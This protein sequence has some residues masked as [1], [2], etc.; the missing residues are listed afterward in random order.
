MVIE[1]RDAVVAGTKLTATYKKQ[2]YVC[3]VE[4]GADGKLA[5]LFNGKSYNSPSSAGTAVIGTACNGWRFWSVEGASPVPAEVTPASAAKTKATKSV[6]VFFRSPNQ[7]GLAEGQTRYYCNACAAGFIADAAAFGGMAVDACPNGH[8][9]DDPE[10]TAPT[11][12]TVGAD[13]ADATAE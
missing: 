3:T 13:R 8:H 4:A 2:D 7:R 12:A 10:L 5:F 9:N 6:K 1:N 11:G